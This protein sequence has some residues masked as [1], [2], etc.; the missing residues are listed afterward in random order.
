[1]SIKQVILIRRDLNMRRG[2]EIA[3]G[4]HASMGFLIEQ[5][6][7]QMPAGKPSLDLNA[8]AQEWIK[9]G[10]AK[11]C[12]QVTSEADLLALHEKAREAGLTTFLVRDSGRTEFH[13]VPTHT[14]CAIG[15][16]DSEAIDAITGELSLY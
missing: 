14:A 3:Q 2:K 11:I 7:T 9:V 1:M 10:M 4:S 15:P 5:L 8:A 16:G 13:G 6:R 12:L